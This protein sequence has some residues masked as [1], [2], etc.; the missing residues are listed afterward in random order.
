MSPVTQHTKHSFKLHIEAPSAWDSSVV[1]LFVVEALIEAVQSSSWDETRE[2]M[3]T[4][5]GLFEQARL[6]RKPG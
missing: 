5:E 2:R 1:T 3:N 4:L 6:F